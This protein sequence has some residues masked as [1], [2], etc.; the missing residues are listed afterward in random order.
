MSKAKNTYPEIDDIRQDLNS[1]KSNVVELT[2]HIQHDG[3]LTV[4]DVKESAS[5]RLKVLSVTGKK[6]LKDVEGRVKDKPV[7]SLAMAF[8]AGLV[9]SAMIK[10]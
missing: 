2:K 5:E 8:A 9:L 6:K 3:R 4:D 10:R 7:Q 1:L